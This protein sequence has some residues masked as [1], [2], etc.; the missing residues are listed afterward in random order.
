MKYKIAVASTD[1][2]VVNQHFGRAEVF[3]I[4]EAD[5][6]DTAFTYEESRKT[7][8]VCKGQEHDETQLKAVAVMLEDCDYILVSRIGA[9]ARAALDQNNIEAFELPGYIEDS[10]RKLL[11]YIEVRK[12]LIEI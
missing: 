10:I 7:V 5:S 6:M 2:K 4:V 8:P 1:G 3:Y 9:G 12:L 11:A